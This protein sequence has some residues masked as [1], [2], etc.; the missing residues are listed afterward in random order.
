VKGRRTSRGQFGPV[1]N[2]GKSKPIKDATPDALMRKLFRHM[3]SQECEKWVGPNVDSDPIWMEI[4]AALLGWAA[5]VWQILGLSKLSDKQTDDWNRTLW[6]LIS[7]TQFAYALG[8]KEGYKRY[9]PKGGND[10]KEKS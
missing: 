4:A 1:I 9:A 6:V 3:S 5:S 2:R 7:I 10:D 8:I